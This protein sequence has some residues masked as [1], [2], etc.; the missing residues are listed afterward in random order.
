[1]KALGGGTL[2]ALLALA[3]FWPAL[4]TGFMIDD[5]F[6]LRGAQQVPGFTVQGLVADFT[7]NVHKEEGLFYYR[8]LLAA[9]TRAE[10]ALWGTD[11]RG[12]HA[13]SLAFHAGN[14]ALVHG[15]FAALGF[16]APVPLLTACL[17]A[18][19]PLIVDDLMAGTG[20]ESMAN[21]LLLSFL[22][23]YLRG[24]RAAA[25]LLFVP[26]VFAK[27]SNILAPAA[28]LLCLWYRGAGRE[29]YRP[30]LWTL[31]V[32]ALFLLLRS[33]YAD[34]PPG[35]SPLSLAAFSV[36]QL[37]ALVFRYLRLV[38]LPEGLE[39]WPRLPAAPAWWPLWLLAL[40]GLVR[41]LFLAPL[42]ARLTAFCLGWFALMLAPRV[43]AMPATGVVMDKW[44]FMGAAGLYAWL[45][46]AAGEAVRR[47]GPRLRLLPWVLA[48]GL[49]AYWGYTARAELALRGS[50]EKNYRWTV[51]D[52]ARSFASYRLAIILMQSGRAEEALRFIS[53]LPEETLR[54]PDYRNA[55]AMALWHSGRREEGWTMMKELAAASPGN[56]AIAANAARMALEMRPK[57]Q[58]AR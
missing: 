8:P 54:R 49:C 31:P 24:K 33:L 1:M 11:P 44:A 41:G 12:Y 6:L 17:F 51:R 46:S 56:P 23:L 55:L 2:A 18:A 5:P 7:D 25:L 4:N 16:P 39:T 52:G 58:A 36:K 10:Y 37:P 35:A 19:N 47:A 28:A 57:K 3:A 32:C 34:P 29:Q 40:A 43:P 26:A 53:A 42:P 21:F 9:L 22:L 13:V 30:L 38:F 14:S 50:D 45:L 15:L 48:C 27:E 20:G